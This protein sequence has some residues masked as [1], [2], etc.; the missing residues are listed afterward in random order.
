MTIAGIPIRTFAGMARLDG[1][2][3]ADARAALAR[4]VATH[5]LDQVV[6]AGCEPVVVTSDAEVGTWARSRDVA[7]L[8]DPPGGGLDAAAGVLVAHAGDARWLVV[9]GDLPALTAADIAAMAGHDAPALAP[10]KDGGTAA[11]SSTGPFRFSYGVDSFRRHLVAAGPGTR[12]VVRPGLA[13][14]IDHPRDLMVAE[15]LG[16]TP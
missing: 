10:S 3:P 9:H 8:T 14:D 4:A 1:H 7:V 13:F 12:V 2:L 5:V 15:L 6:A 11:I 16:V